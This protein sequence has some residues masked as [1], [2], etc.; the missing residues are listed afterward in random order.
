MNV[1]TDYLLTLGK[2]ADEKPNHENSRKWGG[3]GRQGVKGKNSHGNQ[4]K[5]HFQHLIKS[6]LSHM[7]IYGWLHHSWAALRDLV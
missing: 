6:P 3:N 7:G 5:E 4:K 1:H 2:E